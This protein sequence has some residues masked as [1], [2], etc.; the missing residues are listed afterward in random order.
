V[1]EF[2]ASKQIT[3]LGHSP[4]SQDTAPNDFFLFLKIKKVLK[5]GN[6]DDTDN[7]RSNMLAAV[8]AIPTKSLSKF[9][10]RVD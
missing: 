4:Y 9:F 5:G 1:G 2:L 3:V 10:S 7:I 8:K 6:L